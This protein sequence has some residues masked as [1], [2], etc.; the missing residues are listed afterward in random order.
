M[1]KTKRITAAVLAVMMTASLA[2]CSS[3]ETGNESEASSA[4]SAVLE[5]G[6]AHLNFSCYNYSNSMDPITNVNSSWCFLRYGVGECLFRFDENVQVEEALCDSYET[7]DY[8]TWVLHIR[9]GVQFSNGDEVTPTVVKESLERVYAA[10][11]DGSGNSTPSQYV[12]FAS[13]EADDE[14]GTVTLVCD[15]QTVNLPGILAYPWYGIVD[16]AVIDSEVVGTGPYSVQSVEENT[17]IEL[18][19]NENYWDG[20]VPYDSITI[21]L[22]EDSSTK[23][24]ALKSG[25]VDLVENIT[26]ASDLEELGADPA[27]YVSTTAG[28]RLGNSYFNYNGVLENEA[29]R[30]AIQYAIDD[31][32]MCDVTVGGM[33]TAGCSVLPSSLSYG[34]DQLTDAFGYDPDKATEI[35][36]E[37]GIVDSDGD[38]YRELNGENINLNYLAY[39]SRNLDE[40]A[41]AVAISLES[42]GIGCTVT[43]QDYDT[44]LANQSA[45]N[46]DMIT[47]NAI[48]VPTGDPTGFLGNFYSGNSGAYGYYSNEEYDAAYEQLLETTDS[49]EQLDLIIKLQQIL[50]DDAA[51]LVHGYYNSTFVSRADAVSGADITPIDYYWITTA[52]K[53][54]Q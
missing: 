21:Y 5:D 30:Q 16:T 33:Y 31:E 42:I 46:F 44:A 14:A 7:E 8:T 3:S 19:K 28:V 34:Y 20:E 41:Q 29:L 10:E 39:S 24:M 52:I 47:S 54:V 11:A 48:V 27:Y 4:D 18:V 35:L 51:T 22:T 23:A 12:T 1:K 49:G 40:F 25:D 37:A 32:T 26:T 6:Q 43:V 53:P 50:I 13:I 45:G 9:E 38:G 2:A 17:S 36:D 15:S